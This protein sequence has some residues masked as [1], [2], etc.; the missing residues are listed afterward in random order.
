LG[1]R[2]SHGDFGASLVYRRSPRRAGATQ[3]TPHPRLKKH[4]AKTKQNKNLRKERKKKERKKEKRKKERKERERERE[5][6]REGERER[7][8]GRERER[9]KS[10]A[11][12]F[13]KAANSSMHSGAQRS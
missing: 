13:Q 9:L 5:G 2:G 11:V 8:R 10:V 7:E 1:G 4:K 6:R 12:G 3:R